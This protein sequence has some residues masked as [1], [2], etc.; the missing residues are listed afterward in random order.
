MFSAKKAKPLPVGFPEAVEK[1]FEK[2]EVPCC[3]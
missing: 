2:Y 3:I 1:L